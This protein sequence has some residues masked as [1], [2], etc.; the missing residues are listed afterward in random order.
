VYLAGNSLGLQPRGVKRQLEA[1]LAEWQEMAVNGWHQADWMSADGHIAR[2]MAK[3]V[4]A[5]EDEVAVSGTLTG[6]LHMLMASFYRPAGTRTKILMEATCFPSDRY[7]ASSQIAWHGLDPNEHLISP[8]S[9]TP[10]DTILQTLEREGN[11]VA[12]VLVAGVN[13]LSGEVMDM[14][15]ITAAARGAGCMVGLDLAHAAGN[16]PMQLH[17]WKVDFAAWCGYKYLNGGPGAP[18]AYFVHERHHRAKQD[19]LAG[20]WGHHLDSRFQMPADFVPSKGAAG[21][22]VSTPPILG[23]AALEASSV[24]FDE[25]GMERLARKSTR[26]TAYLDA[27]VRQRLSDHVEI[28]TPASRGAQLSLRIRGGRRVFESLRTLGVMCD[29]REPDIVRVAPAPFYNSFGDLIQF[30]DRL[31]NAILP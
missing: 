20:W 22:L 26:L 29:W 23:L 25:V 28:V 6:N 12:L 10:S 17:D 15:A 24:M 9:P 14:A 8:E 2:R 11:R 31:Q 18:A 5:R 1:R 21:W 16:V 19:R 3:I 27:L 13:Y 7:A 4:G 30:A